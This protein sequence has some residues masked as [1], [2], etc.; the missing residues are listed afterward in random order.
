MVGSNQQPLIRSGIV[1]TRDL[2]AQ[3][4][5]S[6][7]LRWQHRQAEQ[8]ASI[9]PSSTNVPGVRTE[10]MARLEAAFFV[11]DGPLSTRK[12]CQFSLLADTSEVKEL[13]DEL[14]AAYDAEGS[15][16]G[17]ERVASG[18]QMLTRPP[19]CTLA[20]S[21]PPTHGRTETLFTGNGNSHH[22]CLSSTD[23]PSRY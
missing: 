18:Y 13:I 14:N 5:A 9:V 6:E 1:S 4:P 21:T 19:I 20:R 16:F 23:Y 22:C 15:A 12:L 17:I 3:T 7:W 11:A 2:S 10:K 8:A